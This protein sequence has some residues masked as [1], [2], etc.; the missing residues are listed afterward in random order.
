MD[1][2]N[3]PAHY[4]KGQYE[5]ID[6]I[7]DT[8]GIEG[9]IAYCRGNVLKYTI[10]MMHKNAPLTDARKA[11]WYLNKT[12]ELMGALKSNDITWALKQ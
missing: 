9:A 4:N 2:V 3:S 7:V 8:L 6:I 12:I 1:M 5:T 10:R 11:Q